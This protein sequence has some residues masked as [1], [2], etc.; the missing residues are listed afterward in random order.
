MNRH[1]FLVEIGAEEMPP[2]S[3]VALGEAFRDGVVAG[4]DS[5]G[6]VH[7]GAQAFFTPR[8]LA[9]RV[10]KLPDRQPEQRIERRGPPVSAAFDPAGKP[11]RAAT[12]FAESCGVA[13]ED[14]TRVQD[15]KG[16]FLHFRA[17]REGEPAAQLLPGIV[18]AALD[19]LPIARRMRWGDGEAQFVRPVHWVVMLHGEQVIAGDIL[20]IAAGRMTRGHRFHAKKPIALR[21]PGGYLAALQ[22]GYVRADFEARRELIREQTIAAAAAE[23][24]EAVIDPAVLEEVAALTEWPVPL[25]GSF[26]P[27]FLELPPEVLVATLQ[28]HQR[29]FPVRGRD[30]KLM[31][32]FVAVANLESRDP[33]QV[34]AGNERV[35]RPR[36]AD[37]A[38]FYDADRK[39]SL[40]SRRQTLAAVTFQAQLGSLADKTA[41]VTALA[42]QIARVAGKDPATAQRAAEL[43]KCDLLTAMVGEFPELQ[44]VMGRYYA[45]H[46]GE[47]AEVAD[48]IAEQYLPR[49]AGDSLPE[50]G[51]G[52][53]LAIAD[54][55]DT[56]VGIFAIG[57]K[58]TGTKDP[59]GLRRSALGVLRILIE[60]GIALDLRELILSALESVAADVARLDKKGTLTFSAAE[61]VSV[62]FLP[63]GLADEIYGYMMERLRAWYLERGGGITTE[64]FDAVL[65]TRPASPL[66]FDD[67]L[68][69]LAAFL[70]LPDAAALTT[71]NKRIANIL[72]KA[73]EQPSPR[74]DP[75]LLVDPN[76]RRLATE[77]EAL[78]Q[79]VERL[80]TARQYSEALTRLASLRPSVDAFFDKVLVMAED[81]RLRANRL[82]LLAALSRLFLHMANLSRLPG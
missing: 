44:G 18:Q 15:A 76:E 82:A 45:R 28:D 27:R 68:R 37:A 47:P 71:A 14:L 19:R 55:L 77:V 63:E 62:P 32:R 78:R 49:F 16:E 10:A 6:L 13:V 40:Q 1:D 20:G 67:R 56:V 74:V 35:V 17:T 25:V 73:G 64:M 43:A 54:K 26:E 7:G 22:K 53:A 69:A 41:R 59:Y 24:G 52:L 12:A 80:V 58:P 11:T 3:L 79:D 21:S 5:A 2:K 57:Q 23:G 38:F 9:V 31:P 42:G 66:D 8:R 61:K 46:D 34:R 65:D 48:A 36:L 60:T 30:G 29:Y 39:T 72:R 33:A 70:A 51:A 4:L 50:T 81:V 75:G